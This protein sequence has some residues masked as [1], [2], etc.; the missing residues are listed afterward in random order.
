MT[1]PAL[2]AAAIA[3]AKQCEQLAADAEFA[4][5]AVGDAESAFQAGGVPGPE[6][7]ARDWTQAAFEA[8]R[9]AERFE[10]AEQALIEELVRCGLDEPAAGTW[11][12]RHILAMREGQSL[13]GNP[14]PV[15]QHDSR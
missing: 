14:G 2:S 8:G 7:L 4:D 1:T 3:R 6:R 5:R 13:E 12:F 11:H 9:L 15:P 10:T